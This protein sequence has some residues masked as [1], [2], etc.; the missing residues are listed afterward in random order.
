MVADLVPDADPLAEETGLAADFL[1]DADPL[2]TGTLDADTDPPL[3]LFSARFVD[4]ADC[5]LFSLPADV[6][7]DAAPLCTGFGVPD[8]DPPAPVFFHTR[9][10]D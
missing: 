5:L 8:T 2:G 7:A 6:V 9:S 3:L 4:G 10:R 1:P